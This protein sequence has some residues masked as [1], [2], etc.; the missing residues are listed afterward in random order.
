MKLF[1]LLGIGIVALV[2][3]QPAQV[4]SNPPSTSPATVTTNATSNMQPGCVDKSPTVTTLLMFNGTAEEA[5]TFY[6]SL[7][8]DSGVTAIERWGMGEPGAEGSVRHAVFTLAGREF[9]CID[10][11]VKHDFTFTPAT[12]LF[13]TCKS[14]TEI[15]ELFAKLS[16]G[17]KVFMPFQPYPFAKKFAWLSDRFGV[18]WQ[19][20]LPN[21]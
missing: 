11:S 6:V 19:L 20:N 17:G 2:A 14:E 13:V 8:K 15:D 3:A 16:E 9:M 5:M 4:Q 21:G 18:S 12:S 7:F 10:S 1:A